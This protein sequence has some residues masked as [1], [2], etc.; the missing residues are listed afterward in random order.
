MVFSTL[1]A[2]IEGLGRLCDIQDDR[3]RAEVEFL[4]NIPRDGTLE[5]GELRL[6]SRR[7]FLKGYIDLL[8]ENNG[9]WWVVDWKTNVPPDRENAEDYDQPCLEEIM[10]YHNYH[11]QYELYLLALCRTLSANSGKPVDWT[12]QIGGAVY[13]FVRGTRQADNRGVFVSKP[14]PER[15]FQLSSSMGLHQVIR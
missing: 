14:S 2:P 10:K 11:L 4:M 9:R 3:R 8:V 5:A 1:S 15:M 13:M 7:G 6:W 12:N